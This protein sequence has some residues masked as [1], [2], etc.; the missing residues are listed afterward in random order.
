MSA[1]TVISGVTLAL[2]DPSEQ[3]EGIKKTQ[4]AVKAGMMANASQLKVYLKSWDKYCAIWVMNKD[5]FI[6]HY[7]TQNKP[8]SSFDADIQRYI[9]PHNKTLIWS[10]PGFKMRYNS[11]QGKHMCLHCVIIYLTKIGLNGEAVCEKLSTPLPF[12]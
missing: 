11:D 9:V 6:Q 4:A 12:P 3:D 10:L 2:F 8:V 5:S 1:S 7:K